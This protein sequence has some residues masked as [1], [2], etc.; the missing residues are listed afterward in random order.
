MQICTVAE[1]IHDLLSNNEAVRC[2][3]SAR[4]KINRERVQMP[5]DIPEDEVYRIYRFN[6]SS[7]LHTIN[8]QVWD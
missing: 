1:G 3:L 4:V 6:I 2:K 5:I 8:L 7:L